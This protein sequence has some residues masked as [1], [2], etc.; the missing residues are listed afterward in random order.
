MNLQNF[1]RGEIA[2]RR[3]SQLETEYEELLFRIHW[4]GSEEE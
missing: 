4:K 2:S 3:K 1:E